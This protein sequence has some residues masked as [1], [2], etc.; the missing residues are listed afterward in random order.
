LDWKTVREE[1]HAVVADEEHAGRFPSRSIRLLARAVALLMERLEQPPA[2]RREHLIEKCPARSAA[3]VSAGLLF[4]FLKRHSRALKT[5]SV[6]PPTRSNH[7]GERG[8]R[9]DRRLA[10]V[11]LLWRCWSVHDTAVD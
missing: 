1:L 11:Q 8:L 6:A 9:L 2:L 3:E 5:R 7:E 10:A 4:Y